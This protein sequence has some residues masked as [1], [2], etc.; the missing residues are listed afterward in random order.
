MNFTRSGSIEFLRYS[1]R[2]VSIFCATCGVLGLAVLRSV[3]Y[4]GLREEE[5]QHI[6]QGVAKALGVPDE[7]AEHEGKT[8]GIADRRV[9]ESNSKSIK[10]F[11]V[12]TM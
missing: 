10:H 2:V 3:L 4:C 1:G 9:R 12:A 11:P 5:N 8:T 7:R 6:I